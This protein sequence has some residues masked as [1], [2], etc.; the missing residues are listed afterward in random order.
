MLFLQCDF[1]NSP[2]IGSDTKTSELIIK[3]DTASASFSWNTHL[4][5]P[6]M[7]CKQYVLRQPC[8]EEAQAGPHG[9]ALRLYEERFLSSFHLLQ[10]PLSD[11]S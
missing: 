9:E 7:L 8:C 3:D 10:Y 4:W 1:D 11:S 6:E 2:L 5:N